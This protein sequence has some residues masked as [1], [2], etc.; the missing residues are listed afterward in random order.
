MVFGFNRNEHLLKTGLFFTIVFF[1]LKAAVSAPLFLVEKAIDKQQMTVSVSG[2]QLPEL[3][4]ITFSCSYDLSGIS[5]ME[6]IVSSPLPAT[7]LAVQVDTAA[8]T[9]SI[10]LHAT[11]TVTPADNARIVLLRIPVALTVEAA[12]FNITKGVIIDK[13]GTSAEITIDNKTI[14]VRSFFPSSIASVRQSTAGSAAVYGI[15]GRKVSGAMQKRAC[16][17]SI[18]QQHG[19]R[20][21]SII[22]VR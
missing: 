7:S 9:L 22:T 21:A 17:Y 20:S 15:D 3:K 13:Q 1:S 11:T 16:C 10:T 5:L 4:S 8:S 6:A 12:D 14:R 2:S 18:V 19:F